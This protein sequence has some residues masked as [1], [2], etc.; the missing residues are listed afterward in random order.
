[1]NTRIFSCSLAALM[2]AGTASFASA[3]T[4]KVDKSHSTVGFSVRHLF[5][6][7]QGRFDAFDGSIE[8][9]PDDLSKTVVKGQIEAASIN[10]NMAKR[11]EHLR[12]SDFFHVGKFPKITFVSRGVTDVDKGRAT[13]KL[14][15]DLTIHGVTRPVVLDVS[16]LGQGE[17]PWGN[18]RAGFTASLTIDRKDYGLTW[19]EALET[20][21]VLVGDEVEIRIDAEGLSE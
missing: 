10:T 8:F 15:G 18:K 16:F 3:E 11:D 7:V 17:D 1:M 2:L 4:W 12:S 14:K 6:K 21:G 9:D 5:T 13:G 19:N 20:G